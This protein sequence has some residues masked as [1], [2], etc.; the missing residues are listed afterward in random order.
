MPKLREV[1]GGTKI[2]TV[3]EL[4]VGDASYGPSNWV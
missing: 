2:F 3:K 1:I 4:D